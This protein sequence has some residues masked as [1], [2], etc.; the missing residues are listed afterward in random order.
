MCFE[1]GSGVR[2][3]EVEGAIDLAHGGG[4][5]M[6]GAEAGLAGAAGLRLRAERHE[7]GGGDGMWI[8]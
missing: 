5:G 7:G 6:I 2:R 1:E 3:E 8:V 4:G